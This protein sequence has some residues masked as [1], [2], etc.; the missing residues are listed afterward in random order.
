MV[1]H[2]RNRIFGRV[3]AEDVKDGRSLVELPDGRKLR[4]GFMLDREAVNGLTVLDVVTEVRVRSPLTDTSRHGI[5][6]LS[7]GI[8]LA[9][10]SMVEPGTAVGIMAAQ[11]IGEPGT[12]LTMRTFHTGGIAG[13]D[14]THGLP[15]VTGAVRGTDAK[16]CGHPLRGRWRCADR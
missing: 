8:D 7:Y 10:G 3:L 4:K 12:Q 11:S 9:T 16:G 5:S 1:K 14:I 2:L 15:R 13:E 6:Q